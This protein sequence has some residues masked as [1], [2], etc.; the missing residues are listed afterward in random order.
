LTTA[1]ELQHGRRLT[2]TELDAAHGQLGAT[3]TVDAR[4]ERWGD[5]VIVRK[6]I[7]T[8]YHLSVVVDDALQGITH[9]T[10]GRDLYIATDLHRLLQVHLGLSEPHYHHDMLTVGPDGQKPSNSA[11]APSLK[12]LRIKGLS[13]TEARTLCLRP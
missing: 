6:D 2:F 10:R 13:A 8:S 9:V 5:A 7:L 3:R 1:R 12:S 11:G 4:P